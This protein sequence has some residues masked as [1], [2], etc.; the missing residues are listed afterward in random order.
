ME[1]Y[2][3]EIEETIEEEIEEDEETMEEEIGEC[4]SPSQRHFW[5]CWY[6]LSL[7]EKKI[8]FYFLCGFDNKEIAKKL[9]LKTEIV[10]DYTTAILKKFN[11]STQPKFMFFFYQHT[12]WDIAKDMI[13]DDEKEQCALWGVQ[14][15]LIPPGIW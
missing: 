11:I 4:M 1:E 5:L 6:Q 10:N 7:L 8:C 13:D 15:C 3:E 14:K 12:G 2:M 9:L